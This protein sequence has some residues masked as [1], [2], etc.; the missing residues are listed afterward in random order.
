MLANS[1]PC[2]TV[3]LHTSFYCAIRKFSFSKADNPPSFELQLGRSNGDNF[4]TQFGPFVKFRPSRLALLKARHRA[5]YLACVR[6][7]RDWSE[8]DWKQIAWSDEYRFLR[9]IADGRLRI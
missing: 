1:H 9:L 7:L 5:A 6:E 4:T 3:P 8:E 2:G